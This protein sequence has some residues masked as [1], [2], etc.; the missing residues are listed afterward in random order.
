MV[1]KVQIINA[2][3]STRPDLLQES[4][5]IVLNNVFDWFAPI[6]VQVNHWQLIKENVKSGSILVTIP[7]L[8]SALEILPNNAGIDLN[9]WV[10]PAKPFNKGCLSPKERQEKCEHVFMYFVL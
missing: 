3:L 7:S 2:E 5:V 10:N 8:E 9:T 1:H 6:D 4:S